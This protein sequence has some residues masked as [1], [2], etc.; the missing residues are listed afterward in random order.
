MRTTIAIVTLAS[1]V[2]LSLQGF[3]CVKEST[4][5]AGA[6]NWRCNDSATQIAGSVCE[7]DTTCLMSRYPM[8]VTDTRTG[9]QWWETLASDVHALGKKL[10]R[11]ALNWVKLWKKANCGSRR[12]LLS[13]TTDW[14]GQCI[15]HNNTG[16]DTQGT[17]EK[18]GYVW[19]KEFRGFTRYEPAPERR[20][21]IMMATKSK[22][23][24]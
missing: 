3:A 22:V 12:R 21:E 6:W 8:S 5:V 1:L 10:D 18:A 15:Q 24:S 4:V 11:D 9:E 14:S 13:Y 23:C 17:C 20:V 16:G 19:K 2:S 7:K